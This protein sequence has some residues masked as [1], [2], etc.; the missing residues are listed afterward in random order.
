MLRKKWK[1]EAL[2]MSSQPTLPDLCSWAPGGERKRNLSLRVGIGNTHKHM[3]RN[4][5][6]VAKIQAMKSELHEKGGGKERERTTR[7]IHLL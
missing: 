3:S 4:N 6:W 7:D 5:M 2:L 1:T